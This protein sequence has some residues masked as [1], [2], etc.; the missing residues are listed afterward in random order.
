MTIK[1]TTVANASFNTAVVLTNL[2][3]G[4]K[5]SAKTA[6][7]MACEAKAAAEMGIAHASAANAARDIVPT[8]RKSRAKS[9][10]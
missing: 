5:R 6:F 1:H 7:Q 10:K 2:F 8:A 3:F 4:T 9:A